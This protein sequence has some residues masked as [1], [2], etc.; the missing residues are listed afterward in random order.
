M[1]KR[2]GPPTK[3]KVEVKAKPAPKLPTNAAG[4]GQKK[5]PAADNKVKAVKGGKRTTKK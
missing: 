5:R 3:R 1:R 4:K 2:K